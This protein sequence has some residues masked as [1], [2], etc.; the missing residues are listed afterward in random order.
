M[1]ESRQLVRELLSWAGEELQLAAAENYQTS[2]AHQSELVQN[3]TLRKLW[4][5]L[6]E[7][8][9][10]QEHVAEIKGNLELDSLQKETVELTKTCAD[11]QHELSEAEKEIKTLEHQLLKQRHDCCESELNLQQLEIASKVSDHKRL[12]EQAKILRRQIDLSSI[13]DTAKSLNLNKNELEEKTKASE[14]ISTFAACIT[15]VNDLVSCIVDCY[16]DG[17]NQQNSKS[18]EHT[19]LWKMVKDALQKY[20]GATVLKVLNTIANNEIDK[21]MK[22]EKVSSEKDFSA[23]EK[24]LGLEDSSVGQNPASTIQK[25]LLTHN[26]E[27]GKEFLDTKENIQLRGLKEKQNAEMKM[28]LQNMISEKFKSDNNDQLQSSIETLDAEIELSS[29]TAMFESLKQSTTELQENFNRKESNDKQ[30]QAVLM[31]IKNFNSELMKNQSHLVEVTEQNLKFRSSLAKQQEEALTKI[32]TAMLNGCSELQQSSASLQQSLN[33]ELASFQNCDI[34]QMMKICIQLK[35]I[36]IGDMFIYRAFKS[37]HNSGG[38]S[39]NKVTS[40]LDAM[41]IASPCD[42]L[43]KILQLKTKLSYQKSVESQVCSAEKANH[44]SSEQLQKLLDQAKSFSEE[45][46]AE[47][48][49]QINR[50]LK[51]VRIFENET[52]K[53]EKAVQE[54]YEE[55]A[56]GSVPWLTFEGSTLSELKQNLN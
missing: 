34:L 50:G 14:K 23:I 25:M 47:L 53:F 20:T 2:V 36:P 42:V 22:C 21:V 16:N 45:Q 27:S 31:E 13:A 18:M 55:P 11:K 10:S 33:D 1:S 52:K 35:M 44:K 38:Q 49:P 15:D 19:E 26:L 7:N 39:Y 30:I 5:H 4:K 56:Q 9:K 28:R 29:L 3:A 54:W 51:S 17:L 12:F 6:I 40:S 24:S 32:K 37:D 41:E 46:T 8:V 48:T 43:D